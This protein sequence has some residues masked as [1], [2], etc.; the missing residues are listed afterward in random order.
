MKQSDPRHE[1]IKVPYC[2]CENKDADQL[3]GK[4]ICDLVFATGIVQFHYFLNPKF[5]VAV[6]PGMSRKPQH[7]FLK[8]VID[9]SISGMLISAIK[10]QVVLQDE[11]LDCR[12]Y[13][14]NAMIRQRQQKN[15]P[16]RGKTNNVVSEQ[17]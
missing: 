11:N 16:S 4:L 14:E 17:V 7:V 8:L 2:I 1:Q 10:K 9:F 15:E 13:N 6:Q 5:T 12:L 3:C